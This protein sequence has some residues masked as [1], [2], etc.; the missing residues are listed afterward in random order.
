LPSPLAAC[1][2]TVDG[3]PALVAASTSAAISRAALAPERA[4]RATESF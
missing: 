1:P 2:A 4:L 3:A